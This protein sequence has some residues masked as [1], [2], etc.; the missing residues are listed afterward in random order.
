MRNNVKL[1]V[2]IL[3]STMDGLSAA[4]STRDS[5]A[6]KLPII[7]SQGLSA[8]NW[9]GVALALVLVA[10]RTYIQYRNA[11]RF[12]INDYWIFLA[13][14]IHIATAIVYQTAIPA[15]YELAYVSAGVEPTEG[16]TDRANMFLRLIFAS[17]LLLWTTLW[18]VKFSLLFFFWRLFDSVQSPMRI[19]WWI[20]VAVTAATYSTSVVLQMFACFPIRDFF[21]IGR[22][23]STKDIFY[24]NLVFH[25][26]VG[27]DIAGDVLIMLIPFP[28]LR[29]LQ[30]KPR[31][32]NI[33]IL[34]FLFPIIPIVFGIL[35]LVEANATTDNV[36][37]IRF[38]LWSMLENISAIIAS[39][40]PALRLFVFS[41]R[42]STY[43][44]GSSSYSRKYHRRAESHPHSFNGHNSSVPLENLIETNT[45]YTLE[46]TG[47]HGTP[48]SRE[49]Q[50]EILKSTSGVMVTREFQLS[51]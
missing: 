27:S 46:H 36:D 14:L 2:R 21:T 12:F 9:V 43:P 15:M 26:S 44:A 1:F 8:L 49:S 13:M 7:S 20:M 28:L 41:S 38:T 35:R 17:D 50:E 42:T 23:G 39:C 30:I 5:A 4:L 47:K 37:P 51:G 48:A 3:P 6:G 40:L 45:D 16:F 10:I 33:L 18:C 22:C 11:K 31:Q 29:K 24:S 32:R 19:F 25:F 34:V